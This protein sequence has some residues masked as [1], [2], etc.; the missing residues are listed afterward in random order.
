MNNLQQAHALNISARNH[1][2]LG[3][4]LLASW[5]TASAKHFEQ[6][7]RETNRRLNQMRL[8]NYQERSSGRSGEFIRDW[9]E[10]EEYYYSNFSEL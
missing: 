5:L 10:F 3:N 6:L 7:D 9:Y 8:G 4:T 2:K 1:E